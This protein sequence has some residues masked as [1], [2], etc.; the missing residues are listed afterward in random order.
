MRF[1]MKVEW[2]NE[3]A[4]KAIADPKFGEKMQTL[5]KE[6]KAEAAYFSTLEGHRG[7]Y[8]FVNM[9]DVSQMPAIAEPFFLW[10]NAYITFLPVMVPEDL[11]KAGPSIAAAVQKWGG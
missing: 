4:N 8:V 10:L 11:A 1:L 3:A 7:G 9:D 5:L 2:P 6:I